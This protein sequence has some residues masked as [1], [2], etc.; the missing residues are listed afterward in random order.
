M[1]SEEAPP[2]RRV[3]GTVLDM[4]RSL[5]LLLV[6]VAVTLVFVPG[7]LHPSKSQRVQPVSYLED[8]RGF[9][10]VTGLAALT[11]KG[12]TSGW[13]ANSK[14]LTYKGSTATLYIGWVT[15]AGKYAA[16][17]ESNRPRIK[18]D[19]S[20]NGDRSLRRTVGPLTILVTGSASAQELRQLADALG[21]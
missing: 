20:R 8:V 4:V 16:L 7:L 11:P 21:H 3:S 1:G 10:Q 14:R 12:L 19:T 15:P 9:H 17:Y 6:I 2:A 13:Y 18:V 5:G